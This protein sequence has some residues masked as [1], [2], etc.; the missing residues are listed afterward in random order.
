MDDAMRMEIERAIKLYV[1]IY[2][3]LQSHLTETP[4]DPKDVKH[5]KMI[6]KEIHRLTNLLE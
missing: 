1:K 2:K 3:H 4:I 6:M 5:S